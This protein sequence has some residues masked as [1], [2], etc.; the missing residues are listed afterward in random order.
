MV[1]NNVPTIIELSYKCS[2]AKD[3][4]YHERVLWKMAK[5]GVAGRLVIHTLHSPL[6]K[7]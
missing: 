5:P 2:G 4:V 3:F 1:A 6:K 7:K